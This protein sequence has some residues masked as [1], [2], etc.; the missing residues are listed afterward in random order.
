MKKK[1][2]ILMLFFI[3]IIYSFNGCFILK[4]IAG[5]DI[6]EEQFDKA[7][8]A[9]MLSVKANNLEILSKKLEKN[10][11]LGNFDIVF[12]LNESL[13]NKIIHQYDST[14]GWIDIDTKYFIDKMLL[15]V[16]NGSALVSIAMIVNSLKYNVD[17]NLITDCLL[18][19]EI[20]GND[21]LI[22]LEPFNI[23]PDVKAQGLLSSADELIKN[24]IKIN[25]AELEK[26]LP[27]M[28][29]PITFDNS[30]TI[31]KNSYEIKDKINMRIDVPKSN[32]N[33]KLKLKDVI[34]LEKS[35]LVTM[36]IEKVEVK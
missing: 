25:L 4:K 5:A 32:I 35:V 26:K 23:T 34:C 29:I 31:E 19:L 9:K 24:L 11:G 16:E 36:N 10:S 8:E 22:H 2:F 28:K 21:L 33:Y 27:Q 7:R 12:V 3:F 14:S 30:V 15:K 13:L 1:N 18:S 20:A 6:D 17:V